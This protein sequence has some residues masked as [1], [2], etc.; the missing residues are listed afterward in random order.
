MKESEAF[1]VLASAD[2]QLLLYELVRTDAPTAEEELA[3]KVAA[4][5]HQ[6]TPET[7]SEEKVE[8]A[9]VRLVHEHFPLLLDLDV[10]K[11]DGGKVALTDEC[12]DQWLEAAKALEVWP[13]D[14][15]LESPVS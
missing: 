14:E 1:K 13:P 9:H 15:W 11:Q 2:R 5:R 8:R 4:R 3:R 6:I 12:R 7:I 10:I